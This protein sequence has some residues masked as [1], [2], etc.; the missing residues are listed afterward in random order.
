MRARGRLMVLVSVF[1]MTV[2]G[3]TSPASARDQTIPRGDPFTVD[4]VV[5][6]GLDCLLG[7]LAPQHRPKVITIRNAAGDLKAWTTTA[8]DTRAEG[9]VP[10][11]G[12]NEGFELCLSEEVLETGDL[13][14]ARQ[15]GTS[16]PLPAGTFVVPRLTMRSDRVAD[17]VSGKGPKN[18]QVRVSTS[19]CPGLEYAYSPTC[20]NHTTALLATSSTGAYSASLAS[21]NPRGGDAVGVEW[22]DVWFDP[23]RM[24]VRN[25]RFPYVNLWLGRERGAF[26][27]M[28]NRSQL[29]T[30]TL[31]SSGGA[32]LGSGQGLG[33]SVDAR[34]DGMLRKSSGDRAYPVSGNR[35]AGDFASD[36]R[37]RVPSFTLSVDGETDVVEGS[38]MPGRPVHVW[39]RRGHPDEPFDF[40]EVWG[41]ADGAGEFA[42]EVSGDFNILPFD[43]VHATCRFGTGDQV[44]R[45]LQVPYFVVV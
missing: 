40:L 35:L 27:G 36:A 21:V 29:T 16:T 22:R 7:T 10:V 18:S 26:D 3:G 32:L 17:S 45:E 8:S 13:I 25:L 23:T 15:P 12:S 33:D 4:Y 38:C 6:L 41:T 30:I 42:F 14:E 28:L 24:V 44:T 37:F 20:T 39:L 1:A 31:R 5:N 19:V 34:Y 43:I 9:L 11:D 2:A